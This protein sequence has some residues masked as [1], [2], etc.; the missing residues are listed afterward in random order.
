MEVNPEKQNIH[1]LFSTTN[2]HIDF[3]QREYK[4]KD[5]T[6]LQLIEDIFYHFE[7]GYSAH[8]N[9]DPSEANVSNNYAWYYLNTYITNKAGDRVFVVDGQQRLT[10]LTL[11]LIVLYHMCGPDQ[12][13]SQDLREWLKSK[14]LGVGAG[15]KKQF[16]M[17]HDR[18][19]GIM[20]TLFEGRKT[21]DDLPFDGITARHIIDNYQLIQKELV[22]RLSTRHKLDTFISISWAWSLSSTSL[23][24]EPMCPWCLR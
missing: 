9:L 8:Q 7:R 5:Q 18:R 1:T 10:T 19:E 11:M 6:V 17:A 16:W 20:Q 24:R 22:Q 14:I 13:D 23:L 21:L 2:F 3:Y 12:F 4:W 15:G